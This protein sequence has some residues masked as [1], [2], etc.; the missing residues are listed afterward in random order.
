MKKFFTC[1]VLLSLIEL[2][3]V[4]A[5]TIPIIKSERESKERFLDWGPK[6]KSD[7]NLIGQYQSWIV[8]MG[9]TSV[10]VTSVS[11]F[12]APQGKFNFKMNN[13]ID[14]DPKSAW[15]EGKADY[16]INEWIEFKEV[17]Q[18]L[19]ISN[20]FQYSKQ[21]F[22]ENSRVK[23]FEVKVGNKTVC[24][25]QLDDCMGTQSFAVGDLLSKKDKSIPVRL[26]IK[27]V[28]EGT[29]YKD[30]AI[31]EIFTLFGEE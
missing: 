12:L 16:G 23:S 30:T 9:H 29:K 3:S 27:E 8:P 6:P 4:F 21:V 22:M 7:P 15:V 17:S 14:D 25:L 26:I 2:S 20:G 13:L 1:F 24:Y 28:Y 10:E 31:S 18:S 19:I 5:Q 11:S